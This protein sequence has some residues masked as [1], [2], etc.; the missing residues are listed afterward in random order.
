MAKWGK[1]LLRRKQKLQK[2]LQIYNEINE[3]KNKRNETPVPLKISSRHDATIATI[4]T[5]ADQE[6]KVM[7]QSCYRG[8]KEIKVSWHWL[9]HY[10][11]LVCYRLLSFATRGKKQVKSSRQRQFEFALKPE[12]EWKKINWKCSRTIVS[13]TKMVLFCYVGVLHYVSMKGGN[14]AK[15]VL[16]DFPLE[17]RLEN[18]SCWI[19]SAESIPW[20]LLQNPRKKIFSPVVTVRREKLDE[21]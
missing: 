14:I 1:P 8:R 6:K 16:E 10:R 13:M 7:V 12:K 17:K 20:C 9:Y 15:T 4:V 21:K 3:N 2:P 18:T 11:Q 5:V 19:T